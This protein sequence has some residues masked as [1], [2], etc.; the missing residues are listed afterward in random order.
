MK[1]SL[2][3]LILVILF[4]VLSQAQNFSNGFNFNLPPNDNTPSIYLPN[5]PAKTITEA[6]RV[7]V[8][9]ENFMVAGKPYRFWGVNLTTLGCFPLK[10]NAPKMASRMR[11]MGINLV[12]FHHMDNP[13]SGTDGSLFSGQST[14][15]LST[16][17]LDRLDFLISE[18]KKN[19][20]YA[21][22]NLNVSRTFTAADGIAG[23][24]SLK[25]FGKGVTLFDPQ[26]IALQKEF[27]RQLL[28]HVNPYTNTNLANEPTVTMVEMINEN[29]LYGM[30]KDDALKHTKVGGSLLQRHISFL[31]SS[32]NVF[33]AK[34]YTTQAA[35]QTAWVNTQTIT[36]VERIRG[37][38]FENTSLDANWQFETHDGAIASFTTDASQKFS[39][40][41]SAKIQITQTTSTDWHIQFKYVNFSF[42][43]D[44]NYV[45]KFTAKASKNRSIATSLMRDNAPYTWYGG[46]SFN[47]TTDWQTFQM[48]F[49]PTEDINNVARLSFSVGQTDGT[50]W[51][52]DVSFAEPT[53]QTMDNGEN[54]SAKNI[55]RLAYSERAVYSR[56]R[57]A[58]MAEFYILLQKS[59]M[60]DMRLYLKNELGVKAPITGTNALTG[61]QEGLQHEQMDY[62]DD[63]NYW[64]HPSFPGVAWDMNN[65]RVQNKSPLKDP[66]FSAITNALNGMPLSDKPFTISE[67]NQPFPNRYRS[68]MVHEWAAYGSFHGMDGLM[69][70][71]Y[72]G[73][74][75][76]KASQ[77]FIPGFFNTARDPS[78][79]ALFPSC[80]YA[81]RNGLIA[82]AKQPVLVNYSRKDIYNSFEKDNQ[83]RWGKY[84]PYDLR[85]QLTHS[86]R[87]KSYN[88]STDYT[89]S[90]LPSPATTIFETDTKETIL[91]TVKGVLTTH[92]PRFIALTG[93]LK[94]ATN[95]QV[96][97]LTLQNASDFGS[98]TWLSLNSKILSESDTSL[99]TLSSKAQN[100][101][102]IW[103]AD[104][105]SLSNNLGT[106]PTQIAPLV[107]TLKLNINAESMDIHTLTPTGQSQSFKNIKPTT[108]GVF[109]VTLS[110]SSDKTLWYGIVTKKAT[111]VQDLDPT[112][113]IDI[114]PNPVRDILFITYAPPSIGKTDIFLI[115]MMGKTVF[116][117]T[118]N[119]LIVG[120]KTDWLD[121]SH[122]TSGIYLLKVGEKVKKVVVE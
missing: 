34:K 120:K 87:T 70:F 53:I 122:L 18:L 107:V 40:T 84:V 31:D 114:S 110:Q 51:L 100:T 21:N 97:Q 47:L 104:N 25:D 81:Y 19:S 121:V 66:N 16:T 71:E 7:S 98:L 39:G 6:E 54:L 95:T 101:G 116:Q 112:L 33:L 90:V 80:A 76:N 60:E 96:G 32:W 55:R 115:D 61:I 62:Y 27:A 78:V 26:M 9:G 72:S 8:Q 52:D 89:P 3:I 37:G 103:N 64:D 111:P 59:F 22:I 17:T 4:S 92:T 79:M 12:R 109:D 99:L 85:T 28:T 94:D 82:A 102:M 69:F 24:D 105:T 49:T 35:L 65:W 56:Q 93:F 10:E 11:K 41:R 118:I 108:K 43:K 46:Q 63:H 13:W 5:F 14:R 75:E 106:A 48:S 38:G 15:S 58:D 91:N 113:N 42:K 57:V 67:Y 73:D 83:G 1:K 29:S 2:S 77:D 88:S 50:I 74:A 30:W 119:H 20:I 86:I 45:L 36:P 117:K 68:E 23:A 44:S